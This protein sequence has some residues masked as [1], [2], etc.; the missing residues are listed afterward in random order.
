MPSPSEKLSGGRVYSSK[1]LG[2]QTAYKFRGGQKK[3]LEIEYTHFYSGKKGFNVGYK[4]TIVSKLSVLL[5]VA[6]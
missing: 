5:Y 4:S 1:V 3:L 2:F 6:L